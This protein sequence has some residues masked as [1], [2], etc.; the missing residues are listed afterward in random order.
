MTKERVAETGRTVAKGQG[1][2]WGRRDAFSHPKPILFLPLTPAFRRGLVLGH[3]ASS[4]ID[5]ARSVITVM[6]SHPVAE[7]VVR[8]LLVPALW[9]QV[10]IHVGGIH[11]FI[12]PPKSGI[13][14]KYL[15]R[16]VPA[17]HT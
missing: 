12:S 5:E 15:A 8:T 10:E 9:R 3:E 11:H 4:G 2:C 16:R 1:G 14:V 6:V 13:G 7:V 17:K